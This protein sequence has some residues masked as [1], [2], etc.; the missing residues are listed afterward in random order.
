MCDSKPKLLTL[1]GDAGLI[2]R[3]AELS[4]E[5]YVPISCRT[6][7]LASNQLRVDRAVRILIV[8]QLA[9]AGTQ[10]AFLDEVRTIRPDVLRVVVTGYSDLTAIIPGLHSGIIQ[11]LM[12]KPLAPEELIATI[13]PAH[14]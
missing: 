5:W 4:R 14:L 11:R 7:S 6:I 13:H 9:D 8:E 2:R 3:I 1:S 12:Q 10:D